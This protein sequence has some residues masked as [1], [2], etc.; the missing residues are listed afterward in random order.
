[1]K[2]KP[3]YYR[4]EKL[5][6]SDETVDV[7]VCVYG[8]TS[9]GV[10][11]AVTAARRGKR[12]AL[13]NP[14]AH[15]GGM[16]TGGLSYTDLGNADAIGGLSREFYRVAGQHYGE[17]LSWAVE[18]HVALRIFQKWIE[19]S[20]VALYS[21]AYVESADLVGQRIHLIKML[22]GLKISAKIFIDTS[23]EGDLLA[24][25]GVAYRVGRE[26]IEEYGESSNG[27]QVHAT[28]QFDCQVDPY[29]KEGV[30]KSGLLPGIDAEPP[31]DIGSGDGRIQAYCFR[32]CMTR[33]ANNRIP[34]PKPEGYD[35]QLY[36]LA[37]RWL[38]KTSTDIFEKFDA[39]PGNKTDTNNHGAVSTDFVGANYAWPEASYEEREVLF[40]EHV[41]YQQGLHWFLANDPAVPADIREE[42]AQWGLARD[43]F[44]ASGNWPPQLYIREARRMLGE[45]VQT[46][47]DCRSGGVCEDPIGMGAYQMDSHHCRRCVVD[48]ALVNEGDVQHP[49]ERPYQIS[50][51]TIVPARGQCVNLLVPVCLSATHIAFGSVRMEPVFMILGES[52]ALAACIALEEKCTVQEVPYSQLREQLLAFGQVL[53]CESK[54]IGDG[55]PNTMR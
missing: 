8:A 2:S 24:R 51:R 42:Y 26:S 53:S 9:A 48:G 13:L 33:E 17:D 45:R 39:I 54:N 19:D 49:L 46:E 16:T 22:N 25:A 21:H 31:A 14:G 34:F 50:Y 38:R 47:V 20:G 12:V 10:V 55:N 3:Y 30:P 29:V 23:Y 35:P 28:H 52:A 43:E 18:P 6:Q 32:V 37:E 4:P 40:Q 36:R 15:L 1:M 11:A 41:R 7:D 44:E 5:V 27:A